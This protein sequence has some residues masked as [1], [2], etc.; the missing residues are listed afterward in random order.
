MLSKSNPH[1]T[2]I[3]QQWATPQDFYDELDAEFFF[4]LDPCCTT[5]DCKCPEGFYHDLGV[6]GLSRNWSG[7][8]FMNNPYGSSKLW[9]PKAAAEVLAGRC[10]LVV[11]LQPARTDTELFHSYIW[12]REAN[13]P[14]DG[15]EV[16]FLKGRLKFG[17]DTYWNWLWK[18]EYRVDYQTGKPLLNSRGQ[19]VKNPLYL[20]FGTR[21]P[22]PFP[23]MVVI[24]R[25]GFDLDSLL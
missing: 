5:D 7:R 14:R 23:S 1:F 19:K 6:D 13:R 25:Q 16:R 21:T 8:V 3:N 10:E 12:D 15:V 18:Q 20:E 11:G 4:T 24:W 17:S 22:A 2:S 9:T